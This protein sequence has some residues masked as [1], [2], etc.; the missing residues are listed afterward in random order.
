MTRNEQLEQALRNLLDNATFQD[1]TFTTADG[2]QVKLGYDKATKEAI[3]QAEEA[4]AN[5]G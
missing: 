5:N 3:A 4:L 1:F 2:A